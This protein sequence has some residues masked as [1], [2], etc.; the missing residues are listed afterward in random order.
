MTLR[1]E[2]EVD[3][4]VDDS[5]LPVAGN[6]DRRRERNERRVERETVRAGLEP[7]PIALLSSAAL[8]PS[9]DTLS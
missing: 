7:Y 1:S 3:D 6:V 4:V 8:S 2:Q 9:S 5:R